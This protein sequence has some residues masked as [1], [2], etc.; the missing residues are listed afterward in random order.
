M[1]LVSCVVVTNS[2][3]TECVAWS[4]KKLELE[5]VY[6][7]KEEKLDRRGE[8]SYSGHLVLSSATS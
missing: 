2:I 8:A 3:A 5:L 7:K 6:A 4:A 1:S